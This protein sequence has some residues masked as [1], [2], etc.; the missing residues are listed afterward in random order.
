[1]AKRKFPHGLTKRYRMILKEVFGGE[2]TDEQIVEM[3]SLIFDVAD[4]EFETHCRSIDETQAVEWV[5]K[6]VAIAQRKESR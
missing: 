6:A 4:K 2:A 1:M 3:S 5:A